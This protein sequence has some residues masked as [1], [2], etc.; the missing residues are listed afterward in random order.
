MLKIMNKP[1]D[2]EHGLKMAKKAN[3]LGIST[4]ACFIAGVPGEEEDDRLQSI[5]YATKL[6]KVGLDEVSVF[7]FTPVPGSALS[8]ALEGFEH[9]S[10]CTPS[11]TWR[12]DYAEVRRYRYRMYWNYFFLKFRQPRKMLTVFKGLLTGRYRGKM[13]MSLFKQVKLYLLYYAPWIFRRLDA[14]A[15]LHGLAQTPSVNLK[16]TSFISKKQARDSSST[17]KAA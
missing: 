8:K 14:T 5:D 15:Y 6:V 4:Q 13:E 12:K 17:K 7:I 3:E 11:P 9:Y 1:F 2:H 10:Q 16:P